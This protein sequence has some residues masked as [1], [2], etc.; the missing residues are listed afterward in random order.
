MSFKSWCIVII[1]GVV[2]WSLLTPAPKQ[3]LDENI[4]TAQEKVKY[5][6]EKKTRLWG[7]DSEKQA[8]TNKS[9]VK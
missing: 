9:G 5:L 2:I 4:K 8:L 6:E 3:L 1:A 7:T